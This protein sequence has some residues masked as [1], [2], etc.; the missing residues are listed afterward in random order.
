MRTLLDVAINTNVLMDYKNTGQK[1]AA[2][3]VAQDNMNSI[4]LALSNAVST[5]KM[6]KDQATYLSDFHLISEYGKGNQESV[7]AAGFSAPDY[8]I[9]VSQIVKT[10]AT[11]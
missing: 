4:G 3:T 6:D 7:A 5:G 10:R 1:E 2:K 11:H 8:A 9:P